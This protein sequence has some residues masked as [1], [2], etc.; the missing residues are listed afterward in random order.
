MTGASPAFAQDAPPAVAVQAPAA[1]SDLSDVVILKDGS[2]FR[3]TITELIA[4]DHVDMLLPSR[5]TRRFAMADVTYAGAAAGAPGATQAAPREARA[6]P[7]A[8]APAGPQK[9]KLHFEASQPDIQLLVPV[10]QASTRGWAGGLMG[11]GYSTRS[12]EYAIL[13]TAPCDVELPQGQQRL[14]LSISGGVAREMAAP[15]DIDGPGR[16]VA[17]YSSRR[18]VRIAGVLLAIVGGVAG[19]VMTGHG[20]NPGST[21]DSY[22]ACTRMPA[23]DG[24]VAAGLAV[25]AGS[26]GA[27]LYMG[28][29]GDKVTLSL[30]PG[31]AGA[32]VPPRAEGGGYGRTARGASGL[33]ARLAF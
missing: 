26:L 6:T 11:F 3:G 18:G 10:M 12:R 29:L 27:G 13:C 16:L 15:L 4:G 33:G 31:A 8:S 14:A 17:D 9:F 20:L 24:M 2:R 22:G 25:F 5:Q 1:A 7:E 23:D 30:V 19:L 32:L 21:C 28:L